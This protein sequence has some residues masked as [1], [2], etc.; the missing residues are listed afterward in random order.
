VKGSP[1]FPSPLA[2]EDEGEGAKCLINKLKADVD[3]GAGFGP[4]RCDM[5]ME[6]ES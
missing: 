5:K 4:E 6:A 1:Y 2:G 3:K